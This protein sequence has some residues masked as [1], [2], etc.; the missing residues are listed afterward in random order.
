MAGG[1]AGAKGGSSAKWREEAAFQAL[2]RAGHASCAWGSKLLVCGGRV[3][4]DVFA[5]GC[6]PMCACG[7]QGV[8]FLRLPAVDTL[9]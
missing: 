8:A 2:S 6:C 9:A 1:A 5:G 7:L 4:S 3:V